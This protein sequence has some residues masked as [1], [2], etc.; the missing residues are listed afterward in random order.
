MA[1]P[2]PSFTML[3]ILPYVLPRAQH[4]IFPFCFWHSP[5][6]IRFLFSGQAQPTL[7]PPF[8]PIKFPPRVSWAERFSCNAVPFLF[9]PH[10]V[11]FFFRGD[12]FFPPPLFPLSFPRLLFPL[13]RFGSCNKPLKSL[14]FFPRVC[15]AFFRLPQNVFSNYYVF[16]SS[17][18]FFSVFF[19]YLSCFVNFSLTDTVFLHGPTFENRRLCLARCN[20][21]PWT[22]TFPQRLF[23]GSYLSWASG[24]PVNICQIPSLRQRVRPFLK[25]FS[26]FDFPWS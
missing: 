15:E 20:R 9:P 1:L 7:P 6:A 22:M 8:E 19:R 14:P 26:R 16:L 21:I 5:T 18:R 13:A 17:F 11:L 10:F 24:R 25:P 2:S 23:S 4:A 3:Q 12:S